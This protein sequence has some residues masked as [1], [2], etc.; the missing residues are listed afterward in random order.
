[1]ALCVIILAVMLQKLWISVPVYG[2]KPN[3]MFS[4]FCM[5]STK[6]LKAKFEAVTKVE[7]GFSLPTL[8]CA[9]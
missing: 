5:I 1:M 9:L 2:F 8:A 7:N 6:I 3:G 4:L